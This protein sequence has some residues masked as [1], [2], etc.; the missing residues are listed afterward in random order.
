MIM[1]KVIVS[2]YMLLNQTFF[3]LCELIVVIMVTHKTEH[4]LYMCVELNNWCVRCFAVWC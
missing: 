1:L 3:L 2:T 4:G